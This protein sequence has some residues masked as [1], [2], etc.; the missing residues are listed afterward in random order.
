MPKFSGATSWDQ[1]RQVIDAIVRSNGWD[2]ATVTLQLLSHL[3]GD[4]LNVALNETPVSKPTHTRL[5]SV[6]RSV[7]FSHLDRMAPM[8]ETD[9]SRRSRLGRETPMIRPT[10]TGLDLATLSPVLCSH[11]DRMAPVMENYR[12]LRNRVARKNPVLRPN[13]TEQ[14]R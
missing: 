4:A 10:H 14:T 6:T 5:D 2:D 3:E 13:H 1:Y 9:R 12:F 11:L 7:L 8:M